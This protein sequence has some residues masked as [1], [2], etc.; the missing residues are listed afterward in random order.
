MKPTPA[1]TQ[2]AICLGLL[3]VTGGVALWHR[4]IQDQ[5]L[6]RDFTGKQ[7]NA[8]AQATIDAY[9]K[10]PFGFTA[11]IRHYES[12]RDVPDRGK[13]TRRIYALGAERITAYNN[14]LALIQANTQSNPN[15]TEFL[16]VNIDRQ[17]KALTDFIKVNEVIPPGS[18]VAREYAEMLLELE[19]WLRAEQLF[20][21]QD[22]VKP[23]PQNPKSLTY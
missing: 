11:H 10:E 3:L 13:G 22:T 23:L 12:V 16:R 8:V 9:W 14:R 4:H 21:Q 15:P 6:S 7:S 2:V 17:E 20:Q 19:L 5:Q 18:K 1:V